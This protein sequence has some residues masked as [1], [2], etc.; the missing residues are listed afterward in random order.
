VTATEVGGVVVRSSG[1]LAVATVTTWAAPTVLGVGF[2][3]F[4]VR[5]A[6]V[7]PPIIECRMHGFSSRRSVRFRR[8]S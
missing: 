4:V 3:T 7:L 8:G 5:T 1:V 6:R 2:V